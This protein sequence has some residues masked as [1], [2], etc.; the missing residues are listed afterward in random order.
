MGKNIKNRKAGIRAG[1]VSALI[2]VMLVVAFNVPKPHIEFVNEENEKSWHIVWEGTLA[3]ALGETSFGENTTEGYNGTGIRGVYFLN[4]TTNPGLASVGGAYSENVSQTFQ[5]WANTSHLGY[6]NDDNFYVELA[7][8]VNFDIVVRVA[9]NKSH[10][11]TNLSGDGVFIDSYLRVNITGT[12]APLGITALTPMH[13]VVSHNVST[14]YLLYMNF[15][16]NDTDAGTFTLSKG[17]SCDITLI[18]LEAYY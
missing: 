18:R 17:Q 12:G 11:G 14:E 7:H 3:Q 4:H 16:L 9:G 8:S 2:V 1:I 5:D 6:T 15:Y 13:G 10:C